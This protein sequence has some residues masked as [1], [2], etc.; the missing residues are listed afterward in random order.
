L[1]L[2]I[3]DYAIGFVTKLENAI[4]SSVPARFYDEGMVIIISKIKSRKRLRLKQ[5]Q[6]AVEFLMHNL[7]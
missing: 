7:G 5:F 1:F 3:P 6:G 2:I 4:I